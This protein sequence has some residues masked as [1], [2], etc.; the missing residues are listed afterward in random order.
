MTDKPKRE[1]NPPVTPEE[2][3]EIRRLHAA[4]IGRNEIARRIGRGPRTVSEFCEREGLT[5][6]RTMTAVATEAKKIDARARRA[7]LIERAYAR[8]EKVFDRLEADDT[9]G[10]KYTATTVN[11]IETKT[12]DH[13]PGPEERSLATAAGQYL[14]QAAKLEAL[15]AGTGHDEDRGI[16]TGIAQALG[17]KTPGGGG[18]G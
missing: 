6:D 7:A 3:A 13:V 1:Y 16:L 15:D 2:H 8:A 9:D 14:T 11:G 10:Y 4:G 18:E 17:W 12:L 5:F